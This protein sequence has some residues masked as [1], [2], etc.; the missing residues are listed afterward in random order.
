M[1]GLG[2]ESMTLQSWV[3]RHTVPPLKNNYLNKIVP[4]LPF[5]NEMIKSVSKKEYISIKK[6]YH[7]SI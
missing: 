2:F 3:A 6:K 1:V 5:T 7:L 4:E